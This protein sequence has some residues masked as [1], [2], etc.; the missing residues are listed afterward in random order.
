MNRPPI[1]DRRVLVTDRREQRVGEADARVS[2]FD[3][4]LTD[5]RRQ[6]LAYA[7]GVP[8]RRGHQL[9]RRTRQRRNVQQD[10]GGLG[11]KPRE[12]ATQQLSQALGHAHPGGLRRTRLRVQN[13]APELEREERVSLA[14]VLD[15]PELCPR[16]F[17]RQFFLDQIA[18]GAPAQGAQREPRQPLLRERALELDRKREARTPAEGDQQADRLISQASQGDLQHAG[19]GWVQ[20]L[21]VVEREQ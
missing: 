9:D 18:E 1:P 7:R 13:L 21:R 2:Q 20:P 5:G 12:P 14:G 17:E 10:V 11:G 4:L 16:E 6:R 3:D 8:M 15:A 19:G